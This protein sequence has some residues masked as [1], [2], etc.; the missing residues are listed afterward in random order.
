[1]QQILARD[2]LPSTL[3]EIIRPNCQ[4]LSGGEGAEVRTFPATL[5]VGNVGADGGNG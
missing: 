1:M 2:P 3:V 4:V 5:V